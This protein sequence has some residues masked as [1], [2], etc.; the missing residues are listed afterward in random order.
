MQGV[1][2]VK[3]GIQMEQFEFMVD[4]A[5]D[6]HPDFEGIL[7]KFFH[8]YEAAK[9]YKNRCDLHIRTYVKKVSTSADIDD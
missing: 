7:P 8:T 1:S 2:H 5:D 6:W 9:N 3:R 4:A